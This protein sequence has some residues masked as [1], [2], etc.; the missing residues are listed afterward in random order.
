MQRDSYPYLE[1]QKRKAITYSV[2]ILSL[3]TTTFLD[4]LLYVVPKLVNLLPKRK[5]GNRLPQLR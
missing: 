2:A 5:E 1:N 4:V 3:L